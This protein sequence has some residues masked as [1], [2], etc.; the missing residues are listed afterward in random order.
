MHV[1][2]STDPARRSFLQT[3]RHSAPRQAKNR[4]GEANSM[5]IVKRAAAV[6][7]AALVSA[8]CAFIAGG[9]TTTFE[10]TE[11]DK[12]TGRFVIPERDAI[13]ASAIK[14][15]KPFDVDSARGLLFVRSNLAEL[16]SYDSY[17]ENQIEKLGFFTEVVRKDAFERLLIQRGV[18]DQV[19]SVDG[20]V[21]LA[22]A[23]KA[24]G[25]FLVVDFDIEGDV[26]YQVRLKMSVYDPK[27]A[28][29][30][31]TVNHQVTNWAGLDSVLF[32]PMFNVL[33]DYI[34][35]NSK[36]FRKPAAPAAP[37]VPPPT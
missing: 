29:E 25:P 36:T 5:T 27:D 33:V 7:R 12:A 15:N 26:G 14:V 8:A 4:N 6:W 1:S 13:P 23:Y 18:A 24:F 32:Q 35:T 16:E 11:V 37:I 34:E 20:F 31:L 22:N 10:V 9:C 17:F 21:G 30:L 2:E 3:T 28:S 19:P